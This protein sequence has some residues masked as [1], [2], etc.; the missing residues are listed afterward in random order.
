MKQGEIWYASLDPVQGSEQ[1]GFPPVVIISGNLLN[2]YLQIV[3]AMPL[4]TKIK[5]YTG[6]PIISP[7]PENGLKDVSE[8]LV[9][10]IRSISKQRL[11]QKIGNITDEELKLALTTLKE[12]TTF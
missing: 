11:I 3:I 1:A 2:K 6:N 8:M 7:N 9:F 12:I 10:H 5:N 4:T